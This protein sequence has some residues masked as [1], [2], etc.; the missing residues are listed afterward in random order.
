[1]GD[2]GTATGRMVP[3]VRYQQQNRSAGVKLHSSGSAMQELKANDSQLSPP[4]S[5]LFPLPAYL[6]NKAPEYAS[7]ERGLWAAQLS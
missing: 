1:M 4:P 6:R 2:Q 3:P 5:C 7:A